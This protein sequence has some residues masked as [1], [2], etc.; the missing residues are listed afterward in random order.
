MRRA[1][2]AVLAV[3]LLAIAGCRGGAAREPYDGVV[4]TRGALRG[5][6]G[7]ESPAQD[8]EP[9]ASEVDVPWTIALLS[10]GEAAQ[11]LGEHRDVTPPDP[12]LTADA[13]PSAPEVPADLEVAVEHD[14]PDEK[15]PAAKSC[16]GVVKGRS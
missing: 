1:A 10:E 9:M 6:T 15:P 16:T 12:E 4:G 7:V 13:Q 14:R 8:A 11:P 3:S 5:V 2:A